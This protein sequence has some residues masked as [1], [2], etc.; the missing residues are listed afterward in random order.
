[1]GWAKTGVEVKGDGNGRGRGEV[2]V[3]LWTSSLMNCPP[4]AIKESEREWKL[5][6]WKDKISG[7]STGV[8]QFEAP[9]RSS[10]FPAPMA[11]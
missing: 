3:A 5:A 8:R 7:R 10:G 1:M 9:D 4:K 2:I 11:D 6:K